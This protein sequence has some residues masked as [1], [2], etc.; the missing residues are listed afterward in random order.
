MF[1]IEMEVRD[2]ELDAQGIVNNSTYQNY[3]EHARHKFLESIGVNFAQLAAEGI[4]LLVVRAELDYKSSL[5]A[6]DFF[7][8][9][10]AVEKVSRV[11][12]AFH[13]KILRS[14]DDK[15]VMNAKIF[16]TCLNQRGRPAFPKEIE[17][18]LTVVAESL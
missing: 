8:V 3:L 7:R 2:Y 11:K 4:N 9:E 18:A 6:N 16:G 17:N 1:S 15:L 14:T 13:Q 12:F 10:V 5:K